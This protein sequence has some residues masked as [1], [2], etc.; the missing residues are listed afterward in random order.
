MLVY[1]LF[2]AFVFSKMYLRF[3]IIDNSCTILES[4]SAKAWGEYKFCGGE[5]YINF[6]NGYSSLITA[7]IRQ[8]PED[9]VKL[10]KPVV[11]VKWKNDCKISNVCV[12]TNCKSET[13]SNSKCCM[14]TDTNLPSINDN[15]THNSTFLNCHEK[16]FPVKIEC[17]N[18]ELFYAE[19]VIVT[20]SLGFLKKNHDSLFQPTLPSKIV[21]VFK[22]KEY[23]F[24]FITFPVFNDSYE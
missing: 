12:N 21:Q 20:A 6:K 3:Q 10:N 14:S 5:D 13:S 18:G 23:L 8:L 16:K 19:H 1:L 15:I 17:A 11:K 9:S 4:L 2:R 7:I 22:T 24:R